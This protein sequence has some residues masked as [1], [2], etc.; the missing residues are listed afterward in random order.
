MKDRITVLLCLSFPALLGGCLNDL[1]APDNKPIQTDTTYYALRERWVGFETDISIRFVN[2]TRETVDIPQDCSGGLYFSLAKQVGDSLEYFWAPVH[3]ACAGAPFVI[4][5]WGQFVA[6]LPIWGALPGHNAGPEFK[7]DD[8]EGVY[9]LVL[10]V[11]FDY[12]DPDQD[13][14]RGELVPLEYRVSNQ[15][16]LDDPR[17]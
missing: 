15:F 11:V 5:P 8:V 6:D 2:K 10:G 9:R 1:V 12:D 7:S 3:V 13:S 4:E 17:T 16:F 14:G